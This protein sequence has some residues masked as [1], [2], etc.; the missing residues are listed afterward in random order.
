LPSSSPKGGAFVVGR[1]TPELD[2]E[3]ARAPATQA[4]SLYIGG[5]RLPIHSCVCNAVARLFAADF[6][7]SGRAGLR[8]EDERRGRTRLLSPTASRVDVVAALATK[9]EADDDA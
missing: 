7:I 5:C 2:E 9:G 1:D 8:C 4:C 6:L 3:H